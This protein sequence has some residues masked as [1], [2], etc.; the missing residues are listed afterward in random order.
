[1][2]SNEEAIECTRKCIGRRDTSSC[3][4]DCVFGREPI[5]EARLWIEYFNN[6]LKLVVERYSFSNTLFSREFG[7]FLRDPYRHLRKK[8]FIYTHDLKRGRLKPEE[9]GP[10]AAAALR[11]SLRT[12]L[13][14]LYQ[15]WVY[16]SIIYHLYTHGAQIVYPEHGVL[17]LERSGKQKLRWIPPNLVL[18]LP[19]HGSI[20]FFLEVP[21]PLAWEDTSDLHET[22]KLYT[23]L[24]PDMMVYSGRVMDIVEPSSNPPIKKP[25][26]II[27]CKELI[28]WYVRVRDVRGP[29]AKPL[30]AEEWR[31]LWIQGLWDGLAEVLGVSRR[32]AIEQVKE[33]RGIRLSEVKIVE[34]YRSVYNPREMILVSK[35][36]IPGDVREELCG[37]DIV[38]YDNI[39]FDHGGL[40][41]VAKK[42]LEYAKPVGDIVIHIRDPD[43]ARI[44][45]TIVRMVEEGIL[46][47]N[48]LNKIVLRFEK[49]IAY[50]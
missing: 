2:T 46:S 22:W 15:N 26:L 11:T 10:R 34:L 38:V 27:E 5:K 18:D 29:L 43:L 41:A 42:V 12:N 49:E 28:D 9:Y 16:L 50:T 19:E 30:T 23:A 3:F 44:V 8:L 35:Y 33:R 36:S 40:E 13:R 31:N 48:E 45:S 47:I 20:S 17:S 7:S 37:H 24:R 32:E 14:T 39:G 6:V 21:R 1:M 25:D 4:I